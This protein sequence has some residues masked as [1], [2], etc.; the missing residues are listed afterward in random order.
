MALGLYALKPWYA[1]RLAGVRARL[2]A[3]GVSPAVVSVAGIGFALAAAAV[4]ALAP[5][6]AFAALAVTALLAG[7]LGCAN[8]DGGIAREAGRT[9]VAGAVLNEVADRVAD[10]LVIGAF[11]FHV[12][13]ELVVA[14]AFASTLPSWVALAGAAAGV[15]RIQGGP[16]G[17]TERCALAVLAVGVGSGAA[18]IVLSVLAFG[19][20]LTAGLRLLRIA[21]EADR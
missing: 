7:R 8:L 3:R 15:R 12:S 19:S 9:T 13:P 14:A 20:A 6:N 5:Q 18:W 10:L 16:V 21:K 11:A 1:R 4:I 2:V 17:K